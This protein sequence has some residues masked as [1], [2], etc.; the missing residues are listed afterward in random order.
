MDVVEQC[1]GTQ[2]ALGQMRTSISAVVAFMHW[3]V[4]L[5]NQSLTPDEVRKLELIIQGCAEET[6]DEV[7]PRKTLLTIT[8]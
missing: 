5:N 3:L 6:T 2:K 4:S 8:L 7:R 1:E